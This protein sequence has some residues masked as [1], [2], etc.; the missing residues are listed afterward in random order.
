[1]WSKYIVF[2]C[3]L[4]AFPRVSCDDA[5]IVGGTVMNETEWSA[6]HT[7]MVSM[8]L[9]N[10]N[11]Y[12]GGSL[13]ADKWVLTAAHCDP[14]TYESVAMGGRYLP[15][16]TEG[17]WQN[18]DIESVHIHPSYDSNSEAY[19][20]ALMKLCTAVDSS[21]SPIALHRDGRSRA[22][23]RRARSSGR[24]GIRLAAG[25]GRASTRRGEHRRE[26]RSYPSSQIV[27]SVMV[28]A[29]EAGKDSCQG[30]SGGPMVCR[31]SPTSPYEQVGVVSWGY[32]CAAA[33]YPGVYAKI[34][35]VQDWIDQVTGCILRP[36]PPSSPP[37]SP[38][39]PRTV[40]Y[41]PPPSPYAPDVTCSNS[42]VYPFDGWCDDGG[43]G[44]EYAECGYGT[45]CSDCGLR[46][47]TSPPQPLVPLPPP[48]SPPSPPPPP[49]PA[50]P[51]PP[52]PSPPPPAPPPSPSPPGILC[53]NDC[54]GRASNG[55]CEDG[56][57]GSTSSECDVGSDCDDCGPR[58]SCEGLLQAAVELDC[59]EGSETD[60]CV[61]I[62][63]RYQN[64]CCDE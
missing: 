52:P 27:N 60:E 15:D 22:K 61:D 37:P 57:E 29:G 3:S 9:T 59:C 58:T 63:G 1:M 47:K 28:C 26:L 62:R 36:C 2:V 23:G 35:A 21:R 56:K 20:F 12:C 34:S 40:W 33:G 55:L 48:P 18:Y 41:A 7:H 49:P 10:N 5:R 43:P 32:Y 51:A 11:H 30:D 64:E 50:S 24:S 54:I 25:V 46:P 53:S 14:R 19:D 16:D 39:P 6:H 4:A 45:D 17:E 44:A 42:C 8:R 31:A 13:I 38:P